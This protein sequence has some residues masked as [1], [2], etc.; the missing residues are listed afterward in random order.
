VVGRANSAWR[1][2]PLAGSLCG[3]QSTHSP[4]PA[5]HSSSCRWLRHARSVVRVSV[6]PAS[7]PAAGACA[8]ARERVGESERASG[9]RARKVRASVQR[10]STREQAA[11][12]RP[13]IGEAADRSVDVRVRRSVDSAHGGAAVASAVPASRRPRSTVRWCDSGTGSSLTRLDSSGSIVVHANASEPA[14]GSQPRWEVATQQSP[15]AD[16]FARVLVM[17]AHR[18]LRYPSLVCTRLSCSQ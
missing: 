8:R 6:D 9:G 18:E 11:E 16:V 14:R 4:A 12:W 13:R 3:G 17:A 7:P 10:L 2:L 5:R 1:G 15:A